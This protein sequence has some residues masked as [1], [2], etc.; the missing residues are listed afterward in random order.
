MPQGT[1]NL[2]DDA[3]AQALF[4]KH[5]QF[6]RRIERVLEVSVIAR[7]TELKISGPGAGLLPSRLSHRIVYPCPVWPAPSPPAAGRG[8]PCGR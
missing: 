1:I 4:G 6:L 2:R 5:D 3:E 7:G 8:S